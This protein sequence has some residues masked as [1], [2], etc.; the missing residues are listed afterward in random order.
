MS[1]RI[2]WTRDEYILALDLYLKYPATA[3]AKTDPVLT[4]YSN[5]M[6]SLHP[7]EALADP[8][9]RNE[10]GVYLCLMNF[11]AVDPY[12]TSQGKVGMTSGKALHFLI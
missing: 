12:W 9:F 10:N 7:S 1:T 8:S 6:R 4:E 2:N 3:P 11:R 5:Y